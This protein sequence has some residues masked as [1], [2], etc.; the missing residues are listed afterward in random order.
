MF[1]TVQLGMATTAYCSGLPLTIEHHYRLSVL[2]EVLVDVALC[3]DSNVASS[4]IRDRNDGSDK[5]RARAL[6]ITLSDA[7]SK[8]PRCLVLP[9]KFSQGCVHLHRT[10]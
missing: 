1:E 10:T 7:I 3:K 4:D 9:T 2:A 6:I 5:Y 8:T